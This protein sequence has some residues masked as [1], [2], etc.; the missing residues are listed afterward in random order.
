[1][2]V[3]DNTSGRRFKVTRVG[4]GFVRL[5]EVV[6]LS[7]PKSGHSRFGLLGKPEDI[8]SYWFTKAEFDS[9]F[10]AIH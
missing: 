5:Q 9:Y 3:I 2:Q 1:M 10:T 6:R 8:D 4:I 7:Q